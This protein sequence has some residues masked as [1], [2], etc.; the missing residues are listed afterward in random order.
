[1]HYHIIRGG[2]GARNV[3]VWESGTIGGE[4]VKTYGHYQS[5]IWTSRTGLLLG[6]GVAIV[7]KRVEGPDGDVRQLISRPH[8]VSILNAVDDLDDG[9]KT[10][11]LHQRAWMPFANENRAHADGQRTL[12]VC[13]PAVTDHPTRA[14]S[15]AVLEYRLECFWVRCLRTGPT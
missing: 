10:V 13:S 14:S 15:G 9:V 12:H 8:P 1:M 2:S 11:T 4:Y 6:E 7:Q 5:A 3:T